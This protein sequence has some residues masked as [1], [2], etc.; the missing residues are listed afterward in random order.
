MARDE[1]TI[2]NENLV[3]RET[4]RDKTP[5]IEV[6][7]IITDNHLK[8]LTVD[9]QKKII[10]HK[11]ETQESDPIHLVECCNI[12]GSLLGMSMFKRCKYLYGCT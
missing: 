5:P 8:E 4:V 12:Y 6:D 10:L 7:E 11:H 9:F 1:I 3:A 2:R